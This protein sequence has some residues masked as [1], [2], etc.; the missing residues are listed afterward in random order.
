MKS[1]RYQGKAKFIDVNVGTLP[2]STIF[3]PDKVKGNGS[4]GDAVVNYHRGCD[5]SS[6]G[7]GVL[8]IDIS[9]TLSTGN[10]S[11]AH[12][13]FHLFQYGYTAF[14]NAWFLEGT[15]R[16]VESAF[17][18]GGGTP[19]AL[20]L[21]QEDR[22]KLFAM[23]YKA[24]GFWNQL[25][26]SGDSL[27]NLDLPEELLDRSYIGSEKPIIEDAHFYGSSL[28]KLLLEALDDADDRANQGSEIEVDAWPESRQRSSD[29]DLFL[30]SAL[31]QAAE[32]YAPHV[33]G[34]FA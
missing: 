4:A 6:G 5:V 9:K 25:A 33:R 24:G 14:K 8:T 22:T 16:W 15:A 29:N 26:R 30:W 7:V 21:T 11:P 18:K 1:P 31:L 28:I 32:E 12:E 19:E 34:P 13:L 23:S 2:L 3:D 17:R 20:P 10:L 27:G